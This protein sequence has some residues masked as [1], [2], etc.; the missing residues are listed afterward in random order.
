[1]RLGALQLVIKFGISLVAGGVLVAAFEPLGWW[2]LSFV[3]L[4]A[5]FYLWQDAT[6]KQAFLL[7]LAFGYGLFGIGVSWVYVSLHT[8]GGMPLWMGV[9]SV[10]GFAGLLSLLIAFCGL[11]AAYLTPRGGN[12]RLLSLVLLWPIFEWI[13]GWLLTGFPWLEVGHT[14][15]LSWLFAFAPIGGSYFVSLIVV[16][17]AYLLVLVATQPNYRSCALLSMVAVFSCAG[18][19]NQISWSTN[20]GQEIDV[21]LI[22]PNIAIDQKWQQQGRDKAINT[23]RILSRSVA[24]TRDVDLFVWP[25]TALPLFY[26]QTNAEFWQSLVPANSA[27]LAGIMDSPEPNATYNA[28]VLACGGDLQLYRKRH[29]VPFGEY[30]P[31]RFL[32]NWVLDYLQLPMS[33]LSSWQGKQVLQC[34]ERLKLG[35]SICY[36]DAFGS[37]LRRHVGDASMLV[38]IS[39]DAW[40]G[41]SLAP[42]QRLQIA[43]MRARELSRPLFRSANTG[44]SAFINQRGEIEARTGQFEQATLRHRVQPQA[45]E[46]P[47]KRFGDWVIWLA[48]AGLLGLRMHLARKKFNA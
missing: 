32:F 42:H 9:I 20:Q 46:T 14:Q 22:Q 23:L 25:E 21:A 35:L 39:E 30:L 12:H 16:I 4:A 13:K 19:I 41:D 26:Q 15:T 7:G 5:L 43:Q 1:M 40:F 28:A 11:A 38:N 24:E 8:Y 10:L 17:V 6:P 44:P 47:Y 31:L 18:L 2:P 29:L 27:L 48:L 33:D 45:G 3:S 37:E 34:G 36:E